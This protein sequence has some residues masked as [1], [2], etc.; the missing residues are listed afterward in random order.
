M[1]QTKEAAR[2][3]TARLKT[4]RAQHQKTVYRT[5]ALLKEQKAV[6]RQICQQLRNGPKTVPEVA[7]ETGLPAHEVLWHITAMKKYDLVVE[8]KQCGEYYQYAMAEGVKS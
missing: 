5:R 2:Q 6:R 8:G 1:T 3:R 4:L 7:A